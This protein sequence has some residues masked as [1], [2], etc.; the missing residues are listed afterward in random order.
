[1]SA[2]PTTHAPEGADHGHAAA[3]PDN[4][5]ILI[6]FAA[7]T[8]VIVTVLCI[9]AGTFE[10]FSMTMKSEVQTMMLSPVDPKLAQLHIT[11]KRLLNGY[12]W[13]DKKND[14]VRIPVDR[15]VP[16]VLA[17]WKNRPSGT[18]ANPIP[19]PGAPAPTAAPAPAP[20][21]APPAAPMKRIGPQAPMKKAPAP[22]PAKKAPA[23][24]P[25]AKAK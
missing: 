22:V 23:P 7:T 1:M 16:L 11:E 9:V 10:M 20:V 14:V 19:A 3:E 2:A 25:K 17:D 4:P 13:L 24:A 15:A 12:T 6:I 5:K 18:V 21:V 8:F